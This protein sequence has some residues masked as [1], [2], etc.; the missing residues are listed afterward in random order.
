MLLVAG[1]TS[2]EQ[3]LTQMPKPTA[4]IKGVRVASADLKGADL[5]FDVGVSNPYTVALPISKLDYSL[6]SKGQ[7]F[8]SGNADPGE[9][10]PPGE[11][12]T[13][14]VPA[15][16]TFAELVSAVKGLSPGAKVPYEAGM[17]LSLQLPGGKTL[18]LP[19]RYEGELPVPTVPEVSLQRVSWEKLTW[20]EAAAK[21]EMRLGNN[22][23]FPVALEEMA[24]NLALGGQSI[25]SAKIGKG[26]E[27]N[28]DETTTVE[29]PITVSPSKLGLAALNSFRS[30]KTGYKLSGEMKMTVPPNIPFNLPIDSSGEVALSSK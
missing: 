6:G 26:L 8:L 20:N 4:N 10:I 30:G 17:E 2:V 11:T 21:L 28:A 23:Q 13:V 14:T 24:V 18:P 29:I 22:N 9:P 1:C 19:L 15:R 16:V 12:Q 27:L 25:T 3:L 5:V 7:V